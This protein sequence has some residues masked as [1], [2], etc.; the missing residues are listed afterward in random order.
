[1]WEGERAE[2]RRRRQQL[3]E[4]AQVNRSSWRERQEQAHARELAVNDLRHHLQ[5]L[6]DRLREDYQL[7]LNEL[8]ERV[9]DKNAIQNLLQEQAPSQE[10]ETAPLAPED[11]IVELRRK[12][13]KL[14]SVNLEAIDELAELETRHGTLQVQFDDLTAAQKALQDI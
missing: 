9:E 11:E 13:S 7:D 4:Q 10:G 12:L 2:L 8:Y 5:A 1:E 6:C 14:G 3:G